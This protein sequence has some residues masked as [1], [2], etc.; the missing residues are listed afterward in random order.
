MRFVVAIKYEDGA[1]YYLASNGLKP[2]IMLAARFRTE[3]DARRRC[4]Q[5]VHCRRAQE[6][7]ARVEVHKI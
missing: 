7:G 6:G 5:S 2:N 4:E 1:Q 3:D